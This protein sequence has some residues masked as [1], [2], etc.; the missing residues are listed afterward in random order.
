MAEVQAIGG[1]GAAVARR[2]RFADAAAVQDQRVGRAG[3]VGR[4]EG[5]AELTFDGLGI[6]ARGEADPVRHAQHVAV[7]GQPGDAERVPEHDVRRLAADA[8][9][10]DERLHRRRHR[11]A[12]GLDEGRGHAQK[13]PGLRAEEAGRHDLRLELARRGGGERLGV[14]IPAE[15][16]RRDLVHARVGALRAQD[17]RDEQLIGVPEMQLGVRAG[18]LLAERGQHPP[19]RRGVERGSGIGRPLRRTLR[20]GPIVAG[21]PGIGHDARP[22]GTVT[23]PARRA[24]GLA[25]G[26]LRH[27]REQRDER[28][29]ATAQPRGADDDGFAGVHRETGIDQRPG[30]YD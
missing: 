23:I 18:M 2:L 3:P 10:R 16:R 11:T 13:R 9:Q 29:V 8:R 19:R 15:E 22:T 12:V 21:T 20:H 1:D 4:G 27:G 25:R 28:A 17:R 30:R 14:R 7:H 5:G 6:V 26:L 24:S